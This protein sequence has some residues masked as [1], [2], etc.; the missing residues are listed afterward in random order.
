MS[1]LLW[2]AEPVLILLFATALLRQHIPVAMAAALAAGVLGVVLVVYQ[3]GP[4]GDAVGI[5]LTLTAVAAVGFGSIPRVSG[6]EY[7]GIYR[8]V[9]NIPNGTSGGIYE[10]SVCPIYD[11]AGNYGSFAYYNGVAVGTPSEPTNVTATAGT[12]RQV[13]LSWDPPTD[14]GG[15]VVTGYT[16]M[17][18]VTGSVRSVTDTT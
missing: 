10:L 17:D 7:D 3:P 6:D 4:T 1:V 5:A 12:G 2:A 16:V 11:K 18:T 13:T 15:N 8:R 9:I 14:N